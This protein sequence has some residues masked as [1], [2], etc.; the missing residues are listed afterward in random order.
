MK[1]MFGRREKFLYRRNP[2]LSSFIAGTKF[3]VVVALLVLLVVNWTGH[4]G[5]TIF[6]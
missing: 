3:G 6:W 2:M 5:G 4:S 1:F